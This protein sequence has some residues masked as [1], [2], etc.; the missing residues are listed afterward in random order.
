M[1][2]DVWKLTE[3]YLKRIHMNRYGERSFGVFNERKIKC[4]KRN[5]IRCV[6]MNRRKLRDLV[7]WKYLIIIH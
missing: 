3:K 4:A 5:T 2:S 6:S 7:C 1:L